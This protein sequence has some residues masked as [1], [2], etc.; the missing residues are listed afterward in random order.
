MKNLLALTITSLTLY[1]CSTAHRDNGWYPVDNSNN[2]EGKA[3]VTTND[4]AKVSLDTVTDPEIAFIQGVLK[5]DRISDWADATERRIGKRIGF[6]YKDS[7]IMAPTVNCRIE[8]GSFSINNSD[9]RLIFEIYNSLDCDKIEPP[10]VMPQKSYA[11]AEGMIMRIVSPDPVR[12][13]VD[14]LIVEFTNSR[15]AELTTGEWYRIDTKS[16]EGNWIQAP[17]SKKYL[18][19]LAKGTEVC[20]NGIGYSLKPDGS[21]RMTVKPWLYDLSDKS[22]TYRLVK[23]FSYPPY[24]IHKSDTA[25]V[26]FQIR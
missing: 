18:D 5:Q 23:T 21:F 17:Y 24:P 2:I 8:S 9:K 14:S 20:F 4:F 16:D 22:T 26:E 13:P 12:T 1:A 6:V 11:T 3:I 25:Y 10:Y 19:L 7:V 15:D